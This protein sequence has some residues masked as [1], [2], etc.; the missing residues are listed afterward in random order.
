M[1]KLLNDFKEYRK[2]MDRYAEAVEMITWDIQTGA[3]KDS[4]DHKIES[5]GF[6]SGEIFRMSTA[7]IYGEYLEE[8]SKPENF[9]KLD[10]AMKLTVKRESRD[11]VRFKRVPADFY[12]EYTKTGA[13]SE[14]AWEEAKEAN[15]FE[16]FR[17]Y[18]DKIIKMTKEYVHYMEP[19][20][21]TY[22]VLLDMYEEGM[23]SASIEKIFDEL[24]EGL[25]PLLDRIKAAPEPDLSSIEGKYDIAGLKKVQD[26][27][28]EYIG[29]DFNCG[30]TG[31]S[32]H[33]FTT[34]LCPGDIR[35]TNSYDETNPLDSMFSAIHEGGHAIFEQNIG[36][37]Y[38]GTSA[39]MVNMMGLHESQSRFFENVLGRNIN[40]WKPVY[41]KLR[42]ILPQFK[43]VDMDTFEKAV[44][45]V[46][47]G[48]IRTQADEVTYCMHI[49]LRFEMEKAI[50]RDNVPTEELPELWKQKHFELLGVMPPDDGKGILQDMHW[51]DGSF[52]Y[53]PSYLLGSVYDG[54]FLDALK[55]QLGD[56][57]EILA[58]G[59][60][61]DITKWLNDNI[62]HY[63]SLYNSKEVLE[64][65]CG[66][67]VSAEPLLRYFRE[68]YE[69]IY[70]L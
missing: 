28:L 16:I 55:E 10:D 20:E 64:R 13:K 37:E 12:Q 52:G 54:M 25:L 65:V 39:A 8:L 67:E 45:Y 44:N 3:P 41:G 49:I 7:D 5:M 19:D 50:F 40:F 9:E 1:E 53:F 38:E 18:L 22:E 2:V 6:F 51:S 42:E 29:F 33:P 27:L 14:Q 35:V 58:E 60:I 34:T 59:R 4:I 31:E 43:N 24:K 61:K 57:D 15:D 66:K 47:A 36:K 62:H 46:K 21:D 26:M 70:N 69:R 56:V 32:M 48:F 30:A 68:K 11:Y 17:P 23:D 63:G